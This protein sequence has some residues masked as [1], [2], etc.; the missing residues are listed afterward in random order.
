MEDLGVIEK[1]SEPTSWVNSIVNVIKP[2]K[3]RI[4]IDP[5]DLNRAIRR[6]HHPLP[7]VEEVV[8]RLTNARVFSILDASSGFWQIE[9]DDSSSTLCTFNTPFGRYMFKRLPFGI[10]SAPDVFQKD[11]TT[12]LEG[13]DA[14]QMIFWCGEKIPVNITNG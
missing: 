12:M 7:T 5:R 8:S 10:S 14:S 9:L 1:Q 3:L 2:H 11:T 6:E 4:C 13:L